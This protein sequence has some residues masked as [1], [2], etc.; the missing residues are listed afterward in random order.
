VFYC[1]RPTIV[2]LSNSAFGCKS[3]LLNQLKS[4]LAIDPT[5]GRVV[6]TIRCPTVGPGDTALVDTN[7][8]GKCNEYGKHL[9]FYPITTLRL[10]FFCF[11]LKHAHYFL[12]Q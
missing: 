4:D 7:E 11:C 2:L 9:S 6:A 3:V 10:I 5:V 12:A 8:K 1:I